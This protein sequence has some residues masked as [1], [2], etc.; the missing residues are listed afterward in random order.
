MSTTASSPRL[1]GPTEASPLLR[2]RYS[3]GY[4]DPIPISPSPNAGTSSWTQYTS[5]PAL[6]SAGAIEMVVEMP[7][8]MSFISLLPP[9]REMTYESME[10]VLPAGL[11]P[12]VNASRPAQQSAISP[13]KTAFLLASL[14]WLY[15]HPTSTSVPR[16]AHGEHS[17]TGTWDLWRRV[18]D[19]LRGRRVLIGLIMT[20]W[21]TFANEG[22]G[23]NA[24][25]VEEVLWT[26]I[27]M[28]DT[29]RE[30]VRVIDLA[31]AE[32][33][34]VWFLSHPLVMISLRT[35][36]S[37]GI[38]TPV[39]RQGVW[40][41]F[42]RFSTPRVTHAIFLGHYLFYLYQ[43]SYL[44]LSPPASPIYLLP[45]RPPSYREYYLL[46]YSLSA[47]PLNQP[48]TL[49]LLPFAFV[50]LALVLAYPGVP[51]PNTSTHSLLLLSLSLLLL[52][53]HLPNPS[54]IPTPLYLFEPKR[55]LPLATLVKG[56]LKRAVRPGMFFFA[57]VVLLVGIVL[58]QALGDSFPL[59]DLPSLLLDRF[60]TW[61]GEPARGGTV[62]IQTQSS[63]TVTGP[64][65]PQTR[66][67]LLLLFLASL[68][69]MFTLVNSLIMLFPGSVSSKGAL[70][71]RDEYEAY[72]V[73]ARR[74]EQS[75][76]RANANPGGNG[77]NVSDDWRAPSEAMT[78]LD[79][80]SRV[81]SIGAATS[82]G[83]GPWERYG[84][85]TATS[86][87]R[88]FVGVI[89]RYQHLRLL[90]LLEPSSN[91]PYPTHARILR[92]PCGRVVLPP[93]FNL[94]AWL[95]GSLPALLIRWTMSSPS[96]SESG[97][98][99]TSITAIPEESADAEA[100]AD[101]HEGNHFH[102]IRRGDRL[103][104]KAEI[105]EGM[106]TRLVWRV[107]VGLPGLLL[108]GVWT[109]RKSVV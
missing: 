101:T 31:S 2:A 49:S 26:E 47:V 56:L 107:T 86:A 71:P 36:W 68:G 60:L 3:T 17:A 85:A 40:V 8:L 94:L 100:Q 51:T 46:V 105:W 7:S 27:P 45:S 32:D 58:A 84:P 19:E 23:R 77:K 10:R 102:Q 64:S 53:L 41:A 69:A 52:Q 92:K 108:G 96:V 65:H 76:G 28:E 35:T 12:A 1:P 22:D 50:A 74:E 73:Q 87:K 16:D 104:A 67:T 14:L 99:S 90:S 93:C 97:A 57:P 98:H 78:I 81:I 11:S 15:L 79:D 91:G 44:I 59:F 103:H 48:P 5:L 62:E 13:R 18:E 24:G 61:L 34:P 38:P 63:L 82:S 70:E 39:V 33:A 30:T 6:A 89:R 109:D 72:L 9:P 37:R 25:S 88:S 66:I 55:V 54:Y 43:L 75:R 106:V 80:R 83:G 4:N 95:V 20:I 21:G 29:G 42:D